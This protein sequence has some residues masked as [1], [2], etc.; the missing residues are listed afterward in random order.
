[1]INKHF[2][3]IAITMIMVFL[4]GP[5][6]SGATAVGKPVFTENNGKAEIKTDQATLSV[7]GGGNVPFF[8]I[9]LNGS[10]NQYQ[11][12]FSSIQEFVD[13][14]GNG[15]LDNG[16]AVPNSGV[17]ALAS[18]NWAFSGFKTV[19]DSSNN[20][21]MIN[22]N[23]TSA[24][25]N[26]DPGLSIDNHVDVSKGNQIKFDLAINHYTW[27][28]TNNSAKLAVKFQISGGNLTQGSN[29]NDLSFG[30][31]HFNSVSTAST[32]DGDINVTT[33][34]D[35]G[36][37]FYLIYNHFN[38]SFVHDPTFSAVAGST[39]G[40]NTSGVSLEVLP[41]LGGLAVIGIVYTKKRRTN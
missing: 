11:V 4:L 17:P 8:H 3:I 6:V 15:M 14:N 26:K 41:M 9:Q 1:M 18:L 37:S 23:F 39:T 20:I 10:N 38:N 24:A 16:E 25:T 19:N 35:S 5:F 2:K 31:A 32:P 30:E 34:V 40:T 21:Q 29:N 33:Q 13:K 12:K 36:N 28:S 7:T 22:F 27:T